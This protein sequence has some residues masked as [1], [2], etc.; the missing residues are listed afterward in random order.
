L[1]L[2]KY[3]TAGGS[4]MALPEWAFFMQKVYADKSLGIDPKAE[5][6]K[7]AELNNN[8]IY[9]DQNFAA[10]ARE[11]QG[12]DSADVQGNGDASDYAPPS[13]VPVESDFTKEP[14]KTVETEAR[15]PIGPMNYNPNKKDTSKTTGIKTKE[16]H[17]ADLK[18]KATSKPARENDY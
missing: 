1:H 2:P 12:S 4:E 9:A 6:Q 14:K 13:D 5:F 15:K 18:K 16:N 10:I 17:D 7:P 3:G 8:P 11:G